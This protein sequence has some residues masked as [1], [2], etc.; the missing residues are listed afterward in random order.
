MRALVL[1]VVGALVG[2][3]APADKVWSLTVDERLDPSSCA[4]C[5]PEQHGSWLLSMHAHAADDPVF[6]AMNAYGQRQ[7]NGEMGDFCVQ[8]HAPVA[9]AEGVTVDGTNLG[10]VDPAL[11][12]VTCT[13]CHQINAVKDDHNNATSWSPLEFF[14]G[15]LD[16]PMESPA[17]P[18]LYSPLHDRNDAQSSD[19][20]GSCHDV[21]TPSGVR[22]ERTYA[23]WQDS[24]YSQPG[25][26]L[27]QSCG[28]CHMPGR[29]GQAAAVEGAPARRIHDHAM[30]GV[31]IDLTDDFLADV[32]RGLV[33]D[34]LD[35]TI[36]LQLDVFDYGA[37]MGVQV[38]LDN[39]AAGHHFPSGAA[40]DRR[41]WVEVVARDT[42]GAVIWSSGQVASDQSLREAMALDPELW[43][44]GDRALTADGED[45]HMFWEVA[46]LQSQGLPPPSRHP[47]DHPRY[48]EPHQVR[49]FDMGSVAAASVEAAIHIRPIG[50]EVL[51]I[52]VASGDLDPAVRDRM[53]TFTL[54]G[55]VVTWTAEEEPER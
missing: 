46:E 40:H 41:A 39:V 36:W 48:Q 52:L 53:P 37:G 27:Q 26:G 45:A 25:E 9:L 34:A 42:A 54:A 38:A 24:I 1:G 49:T 6:M 13:A 19:L 5:H 8:C 33:Q 28:A 20:C 31:D 35:S 16:R 10:T 22:L 29:D 12:G 47:V 3:G 4:G 32:Q 15:A 50:R 2:C 43:W 17:H 11:R 23:E 30:P 21:V 44:L 55:S 51:D 7:T 18:H 14:R